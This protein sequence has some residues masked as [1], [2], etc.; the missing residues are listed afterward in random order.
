M[1][2]VCPPTDC[3]IARGSKTP[4]LPEWEVEWLKLKQRERERL[5]LP[6]EYTEELVDFLKPKRKKDEKP[7][8]GGGAL[9]ACL[10]GVG[11]ALA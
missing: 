7:V 10:L 4:E 8:R 6:P 5:Y 3:R 1:S 11:A 9:R 2:V